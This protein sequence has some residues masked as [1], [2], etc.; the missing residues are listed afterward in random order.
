MHVNQKLFLRGM[1]QLGN[2]HS[3]SEVLQESCKVFTCVPYGG[4]VNSINEVRYRLISNASKLVE[5]YFFDLRKKFL[6]QENIRK[7]FLKQEDLSS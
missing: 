6:N 3:I 2:S 4:A 5:K 7:F 1:Q